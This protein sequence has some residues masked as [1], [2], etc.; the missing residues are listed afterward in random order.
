MA[1]SSYQGQYPHGVQGVTGYTVVGQD[2][3][4]LPCIIACGSGATNDA[5]IVSAIGADTLWA[6]GSL[7]ISCVDG[8]G[9]LWIKQADT[10]VDVQA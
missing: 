8:A 9:K 4:G 6:D 7:Y 3:N 10:W 1:E 2:A 5:G